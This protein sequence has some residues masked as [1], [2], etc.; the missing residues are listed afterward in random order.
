MRYPS[1][2]IFTSRNNVPDISDGCS[3]VNTLTHKAAELFWCIEPLSKMNDLLQA[4]PQLNE[5]KFVVPDGSRYKWMWDVAYEPLVTPR[6]LV[7]ALI[8]THRQGLQTLRLDFHHYYDLSD[9]ELLEEAETLEDCDY[10]YPSFQGFESLTH[11][12]IEFEKLVKIRHLPPTLV[13]LSLQYCRFASLDGEF[14][15]DLVL[16]KGKWCPAIKSVMVT[17]REETNEGIAAVQ[18]HARSLDISA[19]ASADGR[20]LSI[21][22]GGYD[23]LV[24][25]LAP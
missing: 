22:G 1:F 24:E 12:V 16:L 7:K 2:E 23:L 20:T 19:H 8:R 4:C 15:G 14:L 9:P 6:D 10:T 17:G 11:M 18:E 25:N 5:F 21:L 3:A 13:H